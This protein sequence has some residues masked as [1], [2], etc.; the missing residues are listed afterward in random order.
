M[1]RYA[2]ICGWGYDVDDC[3]LAPSAFSFPWTMQSSQI[4]HRFFESLRLYTHTRRGRGKWSTGRSNLVKPS[5][6][7]KL[8]F[9]YIRSN[10]CA[11]VFKTWCTRHEAAC[12]EAER[13]DMNETLWIWK[14]WK[15]IGEVFFIVAWVTHRRYYNRMILWEV[16]EGGPG[17]HPHKTSNLRSWPS[18]KMQKAK[19]SSSQRQSCHGCISPFHCPLHI[20]CITF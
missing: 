16:S 19:T 2:Y 9:F 14:E 15:L 4:S 20:E 6:I 12:H 8:C 3:T 18:S 10:V 5:D 13:E 1:W 11:L 17:P 7:A